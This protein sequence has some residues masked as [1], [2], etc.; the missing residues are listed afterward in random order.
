MLKRI[1]SG[2]LMLMVLVGTVGVSY[3]SH[4]CGGNFV[5]SQFSFVPKTLSCGM[6]KEA[7]K[8]SDG[9]ESLT[10]KCC[11][12]EH[13]SFELSD[14][15][16]VYQIFTPSFYSEF[17]IPVSILEG[18]DFISESDYSFFGYS[19]PPEDRDL[20]LFHQSFLI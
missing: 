12:N 2:L 14:N 18:Y 8:N 15:L 7:E 11:S 20:I 5:K 17:L 10:R 16:D 6:K 3:D 4:Y 1:I 13:T 9:K 19:P